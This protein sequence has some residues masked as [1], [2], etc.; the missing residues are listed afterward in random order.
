[1]NWLDG[2]IIVML[3]IPT[4]IGFKRGLIGTVVP[5]VGI[6]LGV[7]VAGHCYGAMAGWLS[8]WLESQRQAEIV[9]FLIIFV[10]FLT[11]M[12]VVAWLLR[13]FLSLLLMGWVDRV[14]G[15]AFGLILGGVTAGALLSIIAKFFA[16]SVEATFQDSPLASFLLDKFPFV[17]YIL[18]HQFD[19]VRDFF[20]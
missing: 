3:V 9:A 16:S 8:N 12:M 19:S 15:L 4:L 17:L 18:P 10:L 20:G 7:I 6:V 1:M 5:L 11:A 14:G 2:I 13:K